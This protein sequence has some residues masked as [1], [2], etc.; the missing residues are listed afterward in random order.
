MYGHANT[1]ARQDC[2]LHCGM[3]FGTAS[4]RS[5]DFFA[6]DGAPMFGLGHPPDL[7]PFL[8]YG[9]PG[10]PT[11]LQIGPLTV[12]L[13]LKHR[14]QGAS[15]TVIEYY[16]RR[17][18]CRPINFEIFSRHCVG[19]P[20]VDGVVVTAVERVVAGSWVSDSVALHSKYMYVRNQKQ[21]RLNP[22]TF[23]PV[24]H[25]FIQCIQFI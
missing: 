15:A 20:V 17:Q 2:F 25:S 5:Q 13:L 3:I 23:Q 9:G 19:L 1:G 4:G 16:S 12:P 14:R 7:L 21:S 10:S 6:S 8:W 22:K 11:G 24:V 18:K